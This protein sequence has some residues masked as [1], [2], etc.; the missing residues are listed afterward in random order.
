MAPKK[1]F[2]ITD[3]KANLEFP[4]SWVCKLVPVFEKKQTEKLKK[5]KDK[6]I[7]CDMHCYS[8]DLEMARELTKEGITLGIGG[9]LTFKNEK[10]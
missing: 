2:K 10:N 8:Y 4:D 6:N 9:I 3:I 5:Y 1:V 7:K